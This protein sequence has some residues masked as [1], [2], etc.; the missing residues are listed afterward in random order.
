[1][2]G[3]LAAKWDWAHDDD[4]RASGLCPTACLLLSVACLYGYHEAVAQVF[5][6]QQVCGM[7]AVWSQHGACMVV[8]HTHLH[9]RTHIFISPSYLLPWC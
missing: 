6:I 3:C 9:C 7:T 5:L 4:L 8:T 2:G 1:M